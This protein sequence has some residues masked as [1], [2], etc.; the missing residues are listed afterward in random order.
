MRFSIDVMQTLN[1]SEGEPGIKSFSM[2]GIALD[3]YVF[4]NG[5]DIKRAEDEKFLFGYS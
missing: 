3:Q 1:Q 4:R 5:D 2:L